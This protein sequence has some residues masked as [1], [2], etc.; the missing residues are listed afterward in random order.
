MFWIVRDFLSKTLNSRS[1]LFGMQFIQV[2]NLLSY[3][4]L[5]LKCSA[6]SSSPI[7]LMSVISSCLPRFPAISA[8]SQVW[9]PWM[10][11]QFAAFLSWDTWNIWNNVV[12]F[13]LGR[14]I[15]DSWREMFSTLFTFPLKYD[16]AL[17]IP[18][19][20][21]SQN[22]PQVLTVFSFVQL[23]YETSFYS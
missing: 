16:S 4:F 11:T 9:F 1:H 2:W 8:F 20:L 15:S 12:L 23:G 10:P 13:S 22:S 19:A 7:P 17:G 18:I 3:N 5:A 21:A 14:K 6:V